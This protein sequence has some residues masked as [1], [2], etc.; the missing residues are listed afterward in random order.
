MK[1]V[2][3]RQQWQQMDKSVD[4]DVYWD[5]G[6]V[7]YHV[8]KTGDHSF[9]AVYD[10][11]WRLTKTTHALGD[12]ETHIVFDVETG[13]ITQVISVVEGSIQQHQYVSIFD[14]STQKCDLSIN[15]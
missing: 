7:Y 3:T 6:W 5:E 10:K 8:I 15:G 14:I 11:G 12:I 4:Y 9:I 13:A 2:L 1:D